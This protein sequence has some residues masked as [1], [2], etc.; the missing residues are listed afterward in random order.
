[1]F[2]ALG[3]SFWSVM[4]GRISIKRGQLLV[5]TRDFGEKVAN[6]SPNYTLIFTTFLNVI[7]F[8]LQCKICV[9]PPLLRY[10]FAFKKQLGVKFGII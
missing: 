7:L 8:K 10:N 5:E 9:H 3:T 6:Q 4:Y 1:M 2:I